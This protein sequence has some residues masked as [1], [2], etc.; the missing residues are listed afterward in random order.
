MIFK[1]MF[2]YLFMGIMYYKLQY[3]GMAL[4]T[5]APMYKYNGM[6]RVFSKPLGC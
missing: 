3:P 5:A 2:L 6:L 4:G 1:E